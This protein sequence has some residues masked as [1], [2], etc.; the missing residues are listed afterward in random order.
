MTNIY[1][2]TFYDFEVYSIEYHNKKYGHETK[3]W[4]K[5][6]EDWLYQSGY[7]NDFNKHRHRRIQNKKR[8]PKINHFRDLGLDG[9]AREYV[10]DQ[11]I[12]H[13]IQSKFH[14]SPIH[15]NK[16]G[17]FQNRIRSL[18]R[19]NKLSQ[20]Y[21]YHTSR[22][23]GEL[24]DSLR[25]SE[26]V[27][28]FIINHEK[29]SEFLSNNCDSLSICEN[30]SI[31]IINEIDD[32]DFENDSDIDYNEEQEDYSN[33]PDFFE[34]ISNINDEDFIPENERNLFIHQIHNY[35]K[36][37]SLK[38]KILY[39]AICGSGKTL[40]CGHVLNHFRPNLIVV[41]APLRITVE[42]LYKRLPLFLENY[43][44]KIVDCDIIGT[45]DENEI[46]EF[47]ESENKKI[48]FTTY[49]SAREILSKILTFPRDYEYIVVDECHNVT[50]N[51]PN[52]IEFINKFKNGLCL[53]ATPYENIEE[54]INFDNRVTFSFADGIKH[55]VICDYHVWLPLMLKDENSNDIEK[56]PEEIQHLENDLTQK[57]LFLAN[58]MLHTGSRKLYSI[59]F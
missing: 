42:N 53:T 46:Q 45:T 27:D 3:L 48:I 47:L 43:K 9:L 14:K 51:K 24:Q 44:V 29:L 1:N 36:L 16:L 41:L 54:V 30:H 55:D 57:A 23:T 40:V 2:K 34:E 17:T 4:C 32:E 37:I 12:Y 33:L 15:S 35:E 39:S 49:K 59:L 38:G 31:K 11:I 6:P 50:P 26:C 20:G 5:I 13:G 7:I 52:L 8:N 28:G 10:N 22:L 18:F 21:L 19:K 56:I 58:G 25:E